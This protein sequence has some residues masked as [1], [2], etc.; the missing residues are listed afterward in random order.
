MQKA[1]GH[2]K[3]LGISANFTVKE[4][5][6]DDEFGEMMNLPDVFSNFN[7]LQYKRLCKI[8]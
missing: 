6:S 8:M 5:V 3:Q 2:L 4:M 1:V 7:K